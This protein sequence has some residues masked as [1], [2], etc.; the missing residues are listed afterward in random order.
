MRGLSLKV[1]C[2]YKRPSLRRIKTVTLKSLSVFYGSDKEPCWERMHHL[3]F[4]TLI[5]IPLVFLLLYNDGC[6]FEIDITKL[7]RSSF[8]LFKIPNECCILLITFFSIWEEHNTFLFFDLL[9]YCYYVNRFHN[10][11]LFLHFFRQT[12]WTM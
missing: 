8:F 7:L 3:L 6:W 2:V 4:L 10:I 12:C 5:Q 9:M 1:H 11:S